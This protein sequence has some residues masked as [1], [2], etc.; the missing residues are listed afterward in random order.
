MIKITKNL[1]YQVDVWLT[2]QNDA[3]YT[4]PL[5]NYHMKLIY[6]RSI[7]EPKNHS[8]IRSILKKE[9]G[10]KI[11]PNIKKLLDTRAIIGYLN[12]ERITY[13]VYLEEPTFFSK[14]R[15]LSEDYQKPGKKRKR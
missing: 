10:E 3:P 1:L 14:K 5:K 11:A 13:E 7:M 2:P 9:Q 6:I 15:A 12:K 8:M 4:R